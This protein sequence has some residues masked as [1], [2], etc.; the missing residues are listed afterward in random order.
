[1][2]SKLI[3]PFQNKQPKMINVFSHK[4]QLGEAILDLI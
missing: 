1:M 4:A 3:E 2:T